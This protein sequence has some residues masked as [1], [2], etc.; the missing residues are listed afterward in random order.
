MFG[1]MST[2]RQY[3]NQSSY[4]HLPWSITFFH[5]PRSKLFECKVKSKKVWL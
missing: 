2:S 3:C 5:I 1:Y 4:T